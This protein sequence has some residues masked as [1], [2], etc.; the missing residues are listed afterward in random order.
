MIEADG[1]R[2]WIWPLAAGLAVLA[3]LLALALC[4]RSGLAGSPPLSPGQ[5]SA[6]LDHLIAARDSYA[7]PAETIPE[8]AA[9]LRTPEA[10]LAFVRE[11]V[12]LARYE[13]RYLEPQE[14]LDLRVA[15]VDDRAVLLAA[16]LR[17]Q[18]HEVRL[19]TADRNHQ[20]LAYGRPE[21]DVTP[22]LAALLD[23]LGMDG[24]PIEAVPTRADDAIETVR[25]EMDAM[26][27]LVRG[28]GHR[29]DQDFRRPFTDAPRRFVEVRERDAGWRT[30]DVTNADPSIPF[31]RPRDWTPDRVG[32]LSVRL[33]QTDRFG[34]DRVLVDWRGSLANSLHLSFQPAA[35]LGAYMAGDPEGARAGL[36]LWTP[37]LQAGPETVVG[38][39]F[40]ITGPAPAPGDGPPGRVPRLQALAITDIDASGFPEMRA[41]LDVDAPRGPSFLRGISICVTAERRVWSGSKHSRFRAVR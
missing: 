8:A 40:A 5:R 21:L 41:S 18:G 26:E 14:V 39:G 19:R 3:C 32:L 36:T 13:G 15:N 27:Q 29:L 7:R 10:A 2:R 17:A 1:L 11:E 34:R 6:L 23:H 12:R 37:I 30:L 4:A 28:L 9:R 24:L 20:A 33:I 35:G 22:E 16:L 25:A 38:D 31:L